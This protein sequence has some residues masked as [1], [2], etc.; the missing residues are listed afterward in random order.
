MGF[1]LGVLAWAAVLIMLLVLIMR[2]VFAPSGRAHT[3]RPRI[4]SEADLG[5][6][7]PVLAATPR[8]NAL[9]VRNLLSE[10]GIR[11]SVSRRDRDVYDVLV[12]HSDIDRARRLVEQ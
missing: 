5:L 2:W 8:S 7:E 3:G 1:D 6:L 12:F 11:C 10:Q 9:R 4:G